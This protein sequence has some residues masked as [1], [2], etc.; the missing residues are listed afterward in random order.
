MKKAQLMAHPFYYIFVIIVIALI[1]LFG[2][3]IIQKL[4]ETQE[5]TKFFNFK[6]DLTSSVNSIY[7]LNPGSRNTY[8]LLLPKDAKRVCFKNLNSNTE[9]S[10]DSKYFFKFNVENLIPKN[11]QPNANYCLQSINNKLTFALENKI[12]NN[13]VMVELS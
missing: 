6:T 4:H 13:K 12:I 10:S 2:F 7:N 9:I 8:T 5:R 3:N 1:F 11:T